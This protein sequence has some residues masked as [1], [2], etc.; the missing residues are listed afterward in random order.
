MIDL[1][2][3]C[4]HCS[5]PLSGTFERPLG[6][7]R[8]E[9]VNAEQVHINGGVYVRRVPIGIEVVGE[10]M[11]HGIVVNVPLGPETFSRP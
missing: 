9:R 1:R 5:R 11:E 8:A 3:N 7:A 2:H 10:C 4:P 6:A